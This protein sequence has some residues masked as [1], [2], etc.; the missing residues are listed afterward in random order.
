[1]KHAFG[2]ALVASLVTAGLFAVLAAHLVRLIV[3]AKRR[4]DA[5]ARW[6]LLATLLSAAWAGAEALFLALGLRPLAHLAVAVDLL[7]YVAWFG[8]ALAL[9]R[10]LSVDG[11][12]PARPWL[13]GVA[14]LLIASAGVARLALLLAPS[15][16]ET[17]RPVLLGSS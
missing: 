15:H 9:L 12:R 11:T 8:F 13:A 10:P 7:R 3:L 5:G 1:M 17:W 16:A 4:P 6:L 2:F 14:W